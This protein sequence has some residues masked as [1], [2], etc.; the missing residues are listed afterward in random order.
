MVEYNCAYPLTDADNPC[1]YWEGNDNYRGGFANW[2]HRVEHQ[3][4]RHKKFVPLDDPS[5]TNPDYFV[6]ARSD[7]AEPA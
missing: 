5:K 6:R 2:R 7:D 1:E 3:R 4:R